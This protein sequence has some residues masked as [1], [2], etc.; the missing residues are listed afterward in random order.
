[1]SKTKKKNRLAKEMKNSDSRLRFWTGDP[2]GKR[3][4]SLPIKV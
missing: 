2:R 1:V 3:E 4:K